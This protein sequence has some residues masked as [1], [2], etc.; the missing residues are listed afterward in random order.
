M[1]PEERLDKL[2]RELAETK[3]ELATVLG[4][5]TGKAEVRVKSLVVVDESDKDRIALTTDGDEPSLLLLDKDKVIRAELR[6]DEAGM[7]L[8]MSGYGE[9]GKGCAVLAVGA[10]GPSLALYA[11]GTKL[12]ALLSVDNNG[13]NLAMHDENGNQG[14]GLLVNKDESLLRLSYDGERRAELNVDKEGPG[15]SLFDENGNDRARLWNGNNDGPAMSLSDGNGEDRIKLA[16]NEDTPRVVLRDENGNDRA[17]CTVEDVTRMG[18]SDENGNDRA[19]LAVSNAGQMLLLTDDNGE[20]SAALVV[21]KDGPRLWQWGAADTPPL[22]MRMTSSGPKIAVT[23][24][25]GRIVWSSSLP[26]ET[27]EIVMSPKTSQHVADRQKWH[28]RVW[29]K[30]KSLIAAPQQQPAGAPMPTPPSEEKP[31]GED[32]TDAHPLRL[33]SEIFPDGIKAVETRPFEDCKQVSAYVLFDDQTDAAILY[34]DIGLAWV[35]DFGPTNLGLQ[36]LFDEEGLRQN[37]QMDTPQMVSVGTTLTLNRY[38]S[39]R[40]LLVREDKTAVHITIPWPPDRFEELARKRPFLF[41][42][43]HDG[44]AYLN[45]NVPTAA[46]ESLFKRYVH[47]VFGSDPQ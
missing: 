3:A 38:T 7:C 39:M 14:A 27:A 25:N 35:E 6:V 37:S 12:R 31:T 22:A 4:I 21:L 30:V 28:H 9:D 44:K 2:E 1:T 41:V 10:D 19:Q 24:A 45:G 32:S 40:F 8:S 18:M 43:L 36:T 29:D 26:T 13:A 5:F 20:L 34:L 11:A 17:W 42:G 15:L 23:D 16:L 33:I 46:R 47:D